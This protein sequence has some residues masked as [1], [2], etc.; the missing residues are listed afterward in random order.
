[1][2]Y[3]R[4]QNSERKYEDLCYL[5]QSIQFSEESTMKPR[6]K[7][8]YHVNGECEVFH[9]KLLQLRPGT[10]ITTK[11]GKLMHIFCEAVAEV[12]CP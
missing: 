12:S 4:F 10:D 6:E 8:M 11:P 1:M 7:K 3:A 2:K 9:G 5:E